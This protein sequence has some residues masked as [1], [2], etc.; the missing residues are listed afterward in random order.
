MNLDRDLTLSQKLTDHSFAGLNIK[1]Q[2]YKIP[3]ENKCDNLCDLRFG[4]EFLD[5]TQKV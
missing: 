2:Y 1:T 3:R 5:T 4:D